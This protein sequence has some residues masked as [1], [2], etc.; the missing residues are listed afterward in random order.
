M[1][2]VIKPIMLW[3]SSRAMVRKVWR[4]V[5]GKD[6]FVDEKEKI[7]RLAVCEA[8]KLYTGFQCES[9]G[10]LVRLKIQFVDETCPERKW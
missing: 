9:C 5:R 1:K 2:I 7:G 4:L 6:L 3:Y 10:C 8:C